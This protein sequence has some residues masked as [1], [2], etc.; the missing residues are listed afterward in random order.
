M[1]RRPNLIE[2]IVL[3]FDLGIHAKKRILWCM[4]AEYVKTKMDG[5]EVIDSLGLS[6]KLSGYMSE[7]KTSVEIFGM[8]TNRMNK[9]IKDMLTMCN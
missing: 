7:E 5:M 4:N 3:K 8:E 2:K 6:L 1:K 9:E